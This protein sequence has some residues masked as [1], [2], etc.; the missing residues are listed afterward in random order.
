LV[1]NY[2]IGVIL[3]LAPLGY[4]QAA[5]TLMGP[6]QVVAFGMGLAALPEAI[7]ILHR[8]PRHLM[9]FCVLCSVGLTL[10]ALAWGL[11]IMVALPRGFGQWLLGPIWRSTYPLVLPTTLFMMGGCISAGAS[12]YMHALAAARRSVRCAIFTSISFLLGSLVGAVEGGALGAVYGAAVASFLGALV[13][14]WQLRVTLRETH[15]V[16]ISEKPQPSDTESPSPAHAGPAVEAPT[17][18]SSAQPSVEGAS[19]LPPLQGLPPVRE[20][21]VRTSR[22]LF[23]PAPPAAASNPPNDLTARQG[24]V[25]SGGRPDAAWQPIGPSALD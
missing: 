12:T 1:R 23:P 18:Q 20:P 3:G 8:S 2:G 10:V 9:R 13:Y 5:N 7:R 21:A 4:I 25:R 24:R 22:F 15:G 6:F 17:L 16:P 11:T 19:R 14:W